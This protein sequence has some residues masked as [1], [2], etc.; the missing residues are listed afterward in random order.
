MRKYEFPIVDAYVNKVLDEIKSEISVYE[1]DCR[2]TNDLA[3]DECTHCNDN[4]F[5][6]IYHIIDKYKNGGGRR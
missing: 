6:S 3:S 4:I 2:L 1:A 5:G